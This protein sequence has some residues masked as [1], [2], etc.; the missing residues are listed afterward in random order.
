M[1]FFY[2]NNYDNNFFLFFIILKKFDAY[3]SSACVWTWT[4]FIK[5]IGFYLRNTFLFL[6][7]SH[8]S[9]AAAILTYSSFDA[10]LF[11]SDIFLP[12]N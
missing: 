12:N 6:C 11:F 3:G 10:V 5:E 1:I 9:Y 4:C 8:L 2:F 7:F